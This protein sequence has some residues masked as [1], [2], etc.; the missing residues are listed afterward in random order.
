[1]I[2][3]S[4]Y[5]RAGWPSGLVTQLQSCTGFTA[6]LC[7]LAELTCVCMC[8]HVYC[9]CIRGPLLCKRMSYSSVARDVTRCHPMSRVA[10]WFGGNSSEPRC[11][12]IFHGVHKDWP[13]SALTSSAASEEWTLLPEFSLWLTLSPQSAKWQFAARSRQTLALYFMAQRRS[14][15]TRWR[16]SSLAIC[17]IQTVIWA[18][19]FIKGDGTFSTLIDQVLTRFA[20]KLDILIDGPINEND[21]LSCQ[22]KVHWWRVVWDPYNVF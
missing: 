9:C 12:D 18:K 16:R 10:D 1:M 5:C 21:I 19:S 3:K 4:C 17:T 2:M 22:W 20:K 7:H 8:V 13:A 6:G 15:W 11:G 14:T